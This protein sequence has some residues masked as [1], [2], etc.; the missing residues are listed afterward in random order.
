M[1]PTRNRVPGSDGKPRKL[2]Y[3]WTNPLRVVK[4][5]SARHYVLEGIN[6]KGKTYETKHNVNRI[7]PYSPYDDTLF[8]TSQ[9]GKIQGS[10]IIARS[11]KAQPGDMVLCPMKNED[12]PFAIG[13]VI[14]RIKGF[15]EI[16]WYG[17]RNNL[18]QGNYKKGWLDAEGRA[19]YKNTPTSYKHRRYTNLQ[20]EDDEEITD[21]E[22]ALFGF[23]IEDDDRLGNDLLKIISL[24]KKID[25][26]IPGIANTEVEPPEA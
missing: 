14:S 18:L 16:Q 24:N 1:P 7:F 15:L 22:I 21:S 5:I 17:N 23:N 26:S 11:H 8:D 10:D 19:Y 9:F 4:R 2:E 25:F 6:D 13:K 12:L 20:I 3:R